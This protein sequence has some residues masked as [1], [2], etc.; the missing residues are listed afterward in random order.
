[1]VLCTMLVLVSLTFTAEKLCVVVWRW[2]SHREVVVVVYYTIKPVSISVYAATLLFLSHSSIE[3]RKETNRPHEAEI[4]SF[5]MCIQCFVRVVLC[6]RGVLPGKIP[7]SIW[8]HLA[9]CQHGTRNKSN[10]MEGKQF[11]IGCLPSKG[12]IELTER[13]RLNYIT[14][15]F[16]QQ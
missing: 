9:P 10:C 5:M 6:W 12:Q 3:A 13:S 7:R 8:F 16:S 4:I 15:F 11:S 14:L 1:M 2:D